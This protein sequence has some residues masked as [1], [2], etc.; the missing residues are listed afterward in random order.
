MALEWVLTGQ[1]RTEPDYTR[2]LVL[3]QVLER[4]AYTQE[5]RW[6]N[7]IPNDLKLLAHDEGTETGRV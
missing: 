2:H 1:M 3:V 7:A 5:W 6:R 4:N